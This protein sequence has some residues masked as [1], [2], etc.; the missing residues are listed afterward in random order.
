MTDWV[1]ALP[2]W[3][4]DFV[5]KLTKYTLPAIKLALER[6]PPEDHIRFLVHTDL[7]DELRPHFAPY[8]V[9]LYPL[10]SSETNAHI[11]LGEVNR[12]SLRMTNV[13]EVIAFINADMVPSLEVFAASRQRLAEGKKLIMCMGTRVLADTAD[14]SKAV[15]LPARALLQWAWDHRHAWTTGCIWGS[16]NSR[17][18]TVL[19]F[20]LNDGVVLH[21]FHLHPLV[22][23]KE[24][25]SLTF[26]GVTIDRD[27]L[28]QFSYDKIHVVT[29]AD[30]LAFAELSPQSKDMGILPHTINREYV[31]S[32]AKNVATAAHRWLFGHRIEIIGPATD[33]ADIQ[34]VSQ[35]LHDIEVFIPAPV[36]APPPIMGTMHYL[37][38]ER[39]EAL[40]KQES[41]A[42]ALARR[43]FI[44]LPAWGDRHVGIAS[45]YI[46]PALAVAR[47]RAPV[48]VSIAVYTDQPEVMKAALDSNGFEGS[49]RRV[50]LEISPHEMLNL[51]HKQ[52]ITETPVGASIV[53][54]DGDTV[55]SCELFDYTLA[56]FPTKRVIATSALRTIIT[57]TGP[58]IG[59]TG[60]ELLGWA[61]RN[62]HPMAEACVWARSHTSFPNVL[63]FDDDK[64]NAVMHTF[65]LHPFVLLKDRNPH[66]KGTI[67]DDLLNNYENHEVQFVKDA[68]LAFAEVS[69]EGQT[70]S[71][72]DPRNP[73]LTV[74]SVAQFARIMLPCHWRNFRQQIRIIGS[75][76]LETSA[77]IEAIAVK[78]RPSI[79]HLWP[80]EAL[81]RM[82]AQ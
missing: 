5:D 62:R 49:C 27:L 53:L 64:G 57:D 65:H 33:L 45:K 66:F 30:E 7:A 68:E 47:L 37:S 16:G 77:L 63:F 42:R 22:L 31:A 38:R 81:D 79:H 76:Q 21:A 82:A 39:Q 54:L 12:H 52:V 51:A 40:A 20:R 75:D 72:Y 34:P 36:D 1:V 2:I 60:R 73:P 11:Q 29:D 17:A 32:F 23:L 58:P 15:G 43:F 13:G 69:G 48:T 28:D 10:P 41:S 56:V 18:P 80:Q 26:H 50:N 9:D 44:A 19:Y 59:M 4:R 55:P 14:A 70:P 8:Q 24:E 25:S 46:L 3:G 78:V 67:D 74:D 35:L 6:L 61:W 71:Y